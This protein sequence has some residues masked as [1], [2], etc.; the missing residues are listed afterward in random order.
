MKSGV[1]SV[2]DEVGNKKAI[3]VG[4]CDD[5]YPNETIQIRTPAT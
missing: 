3:R 5:M 1:K 4:L 2:I